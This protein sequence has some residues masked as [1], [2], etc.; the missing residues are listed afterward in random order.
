MGETEYQKPVDLPFVRLRFYMV[1]DRG[2][3]EQFLIQLE[4]NR[5]M[6]D[7]GPDRWGPIARFD[8]NPAAED[9]HDVASEGLHLDLLD[10]DGDKHTV[11]RGFP[12]KPLQQCPEY[13]ERYLVK[14]SSQLVREYERRA[15]IGAGYETL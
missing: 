15:G 1:A 10:I 12:F 3:P 13:C 6:V 14:K 4:Y 9:G 5:A 8:H 2:V 11:R 7:L